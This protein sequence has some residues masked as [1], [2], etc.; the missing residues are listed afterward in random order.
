MITRADIKD[1]TLAVWSDWLTLLSGP[2]SVPAAA[3]AYW[4]AE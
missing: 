3:A 2:L 4:V 1:F